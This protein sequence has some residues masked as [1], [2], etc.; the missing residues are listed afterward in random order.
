MPNPSFVA[1]TVAQFATTATPEVVTLAV[2]SGAAAG[3]LLVAVC[4][5]QSSAATST[6]P[7]VSS[8]TWSNRGSVW[9]GS[10]RYGSI[11]SKVMAGGDTTFDFTLPSALGAQRHEGI[12]VA[13]RDTSGFDV[14]SGW[15]RAVTGAAIGSTGLAGVVAGAF[16]LYFHFNTTGAGNVGTLV[17]DPPSGW[18]KIGPAV[19][20][21]TGAASS[22]WLT[23]FYKAG[24]SGGSEAAPSSSI[25]GPTL[26]DWKTAGMSFAP[27]VFAAPGVTRTPLP[28]AAAAR[29]ANY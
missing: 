2:P 18:T 23:G 7:T 25:T 19:Q 11:Q 29:A 3:D 12:M 4:T 14:E 16:L 17:T 9:N 6:F 1:A 8:G 24:S 27:S 13:I 21:V 5:G 26:A 15:F 10:G 20:D 22:N 28:S